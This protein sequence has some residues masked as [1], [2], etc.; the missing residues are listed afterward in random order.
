[1]EI[2][3]GLEVRHAYMAEYD[4][5]RKAPAFTGLL[6]AL[7]GGHLYEKNNSDWAGGVEVI[8]MHAGY[9]KGKKFD[10]RDWRGHLALDASGWPGFPLSQAHDPERPLVIKPAG[11]GPVVIDGEGMPELFNMAGSE[12]II[13]EGLTLQ[14]AGIIFQ[15]SSRGQERPSR[16]ITIRN[17][18][19][20]N[21]AH[22]AY[23]DHPGNRNI[24]II[25]CEI[26]GRQERVLGAWGD[27]PTR[28][29]I[30]LSGKGHVFAYNRV[31]DVF[32]YVNAGQPTRC[33]DVY[34]N[35]I[36][37]ASDNSICFNGDARNC[38]ALRNRIY[39]GGSMQMDNRNDSGPTYWIRNVVYNAKSN[40]AWKTGNLGG[41]VALHNTTSLYPLHFNVYNYGRVQNNLFL[42]AP[43]KGGKPSKALRAVSEQETM[44]NHNGYLLK[45]AEFFFDK[46]RMA[47]FSAFQKASGMERDGIAV[48]FSIFKNAI[49]PHG[50]EKD[51]PHNVQLLDPA[52]FDLSLAA[53]ANAVDAG[54]VIPNVNEDFTG[55]APDLGAYEKGKALPHYGPRSEMPGM[56]Y[57]TEPEQFADAKIAVKDPG[58]AVL[59]VS[60]GTPWPYIDPA[61]RVWQGDQELDSSYDWKNDWGHIGNPN[62]WYSQAKKGKEAGA[63]LSRI[64]LY[65]R[66]D[67]D[68]YIFSL[69]EGKYTLRLHFM[70]RWGEGRVFDVYVNNRLALDDFDIFKIGG[71]NNKP[72][73]KEMTTEV[74]GGKLMIE[75]KRE[76]Q[77]TPVINGIEIFKLSGE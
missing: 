6:H 26:I 27:T 7:W 10:K 70:E 29:A 77:S 75:L 58:E 9:Y 63:P 5:E 59:R 38:R 54:M 72:V 66:S 1:M 3:E 73:V 55:K 41:I 76:G 2:P 24:T 43:G 32:D 69:P 34:N 25:D 44:L 42:G 47:D 57:M 51:W 48:D 21:M 64:Y 62:G 39:N 60:C 11:D 46:E 37:R 13:I 53:G 31:R 68:A 61:G 56:W 67:P 12:N 16:N 45:N 15:F 23:G 33:L 19:I 35:D 74:N 22:V 14:N 52:D 4:G 28:Q 36:Q 71:G 65:E 40:M 30:T 17:C 50:L 49:S 20:R 8:L 18:V